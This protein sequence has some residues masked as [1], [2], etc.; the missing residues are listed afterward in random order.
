MSK[1]RKYVVVHFADHKSAMDAFKLF[2]A[3]HP[4]QLIASRDLSRVEHETV[5]IQEDSV[6]VPRN[7][8]RAFLLQCYGSIPLPFES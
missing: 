2:R 3:A 4:T 8:A 6:D 5:Y 7:M 1:N